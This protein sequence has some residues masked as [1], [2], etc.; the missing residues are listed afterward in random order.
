MPVR[1]A[2]LF[3]TASKIYAAARAARRREAVA[4]DADANIFLVGDFHGPGLTF[5]GNVLIDSDDQG[6]G[7]RDMFL[8]WLDGSGNHVF[9]SAYGSPGDES[10]VA[11]G[12]DGMGNV[13]VTGWF[14]QGIDFGAG[15]VRAAG[16]TDMF[17]ARLSR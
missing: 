14:D 3:L 5:G 8:A 15:L 7:T 16:A 1:S 13:V 4:V 2:D 10:P 6:R 9:S 17:V 12:I 11:V